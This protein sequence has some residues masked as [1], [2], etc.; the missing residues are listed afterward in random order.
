M[1]RVSFGSVSFLLPSNA[2]VK[3]QKAAMAEASVETQILVVPHHGANKTDV[4]FIAAV[5]PVLAI[6]PRGTGKFDA[7]PSRDVVTELSAWRTPRRTDVDG[8]VMVAT[9]GKTIEF[10]RG[11]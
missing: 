4:P 11:R 7:E 8:R 5:K 9:D 10:E 3:E 1:L 2:S 6:I